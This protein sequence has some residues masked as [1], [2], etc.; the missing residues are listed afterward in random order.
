M[1]NPDRSNIKLFVKKVSAS[2]PLRVVFDWLLKMLDQGNCPRV[3]VFCKTINDTGK[4]YNVFRKARRGKPQKHQMYHASTPQ[5][6]KDA[7]SSDMADA[8]GSIRVLFCTNAVGMGVNYKGVELVVNYG[9]PQDMDTLNQHLGR[10]G[11][12][13]A[14]VTHILIFNGKQLW[15]VDADMLAYSKSDA[16]CR[17]DVMLSCYN[18]KPDAKR[19]GHLCCDSC[20]SECK[21]GTEKCGDILGHPAVEVS[22]DYFRCK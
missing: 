5:E 21:C 12:D 16:K 1:D 6:V 3:L 20:T 22:S 8:D 11:R 7:V 17:R 18:A 19:L 10:A 4:L 9:A 15:N 13:G 14:Q 2:L